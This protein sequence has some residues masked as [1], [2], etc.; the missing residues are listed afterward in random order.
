MHRA[1]RGK[2]LHGNPCAP[3]RPNLADPAATAFARHPCDFGSA[4]SGSAVPR[5]AVLTCLLSCLKAQLFLACA[6]HDGLGV[7]IA[8][9]SLKP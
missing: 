4:A 2:P 1:L 5:D 3:W 9:E 6:R 7:L 8:W